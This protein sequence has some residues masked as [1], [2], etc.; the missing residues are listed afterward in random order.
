MS[1][2]TSLRRVIADWIDPTRATRETAATK[3]TRAIKRDVANAHGAIL[4]TGSHRESSGTLG[5][6][7]HLR[8]L[9][10]DDVL[11]GRA[12]GLLILDYIATDLALKDARWRYA[13][14][15]LRTSLLTTRIGA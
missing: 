3:T 2:Q 11:R 8:A 5:H 6:R 13:E 4:I 9:T 1:N 12:R 14:Q 15:M 10:V 7:A